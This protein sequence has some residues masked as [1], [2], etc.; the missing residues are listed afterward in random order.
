[1]EPPLISC[2]ILVSN[3]E[4]YLQKAVESVLQQGRDE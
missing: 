2:I 4:R 1:M 3:G